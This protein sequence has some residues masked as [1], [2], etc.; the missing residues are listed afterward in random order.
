MPITASALLWLLLLL[1]LLQLL[2]LRLQAD[3]AFCLSLSLR[4]LLFCLSSCEGVGLVNGS[5]TLFG[6]SAQ[7]VYE[8]QGE[9][10]EGVRQEVRGVK[11]EE[12]GEIKVEGEPHTSCA[13]VDGMNDGHTSD[14]SQGAVCNVTIR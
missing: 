13:H 1:R 4:F 3:L 6:R 10:V 5:H 8:L 9:E 14:L 2:Y 7:V 12:I 11:D